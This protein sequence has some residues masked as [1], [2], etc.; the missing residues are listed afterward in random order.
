MSESK[1][2]LAAIIDNCQPNRIVALGETAQ[3][4][5]QRWSEHSECEVTHLTLEDT[6]NELSFADVQDLGLVSDTLEHV[7]FQQGQ[8]LI[9]Q[10]RNYGT[11]QIAVLVQDQSGWDLNDFIA[12]GFKRESQLGEDGG[13]NPSTLYT[14]NISSYNH[15]RSWNNPRFWANPHMWGKT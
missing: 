9:G 10:L 11:R 1:Q 8:I 3:R 12:L 14:Y 5:A 6:Q 13:R 15:Q 2:A 7:S 4:L